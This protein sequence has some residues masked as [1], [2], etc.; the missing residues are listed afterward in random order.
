MSRPFQ[1]NSEKKGLLAI[2]L[3]ATLLKKLIDAAE[4]E[5]LSKEEL[6]HKILKASL[7]K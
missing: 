2:E 4:N 1:A 7:E 5:N 6:I 3:K